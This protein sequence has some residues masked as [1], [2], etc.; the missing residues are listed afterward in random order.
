MNPLP[1][2][3][4][5]RERELREHNRYITTQQNGTI[6]IKGVAK[7]LGLYNN[8]A[9]YDLW[10]SNYNQE[11]IQQREHIAR[12]RIGR[13]IQ[14]RLYVEPPL[15]QFNV[16]T[17]KSI[18]Y[19]VARTDLIRPNTTTT[20]ISTFHYQNLKSIPEIRNNLIQI[21]NT[22]DRAYKISL[23]FE[24]MFEL[25]VYIEA[26][27]TTNARYEYQYKIFR[28]TSNKYF[29]S[30]V[31]INKIEDIMNIN[32]DKELLHGYI[33]GMRPSSSHKVI[34]I[35][36]MT[37][38]VLNLKKYKYLQ[39]FVYGSEAGNAIVRQR[40][41]ELRQIR[42]ILPHHIGSG[43]DLPNYITKNRNI[44]SMNNATNNM[45]FWNCLGYYY[46]G[47]KR[48]LKK[49]N[50][51]FTTFYGKKPD[52][53]YKGI[54]I[55]SELDVFESIEGNVGINIYN[56][57]NTSKY[58]LIRKSNKSQ[59]MDLLLYENHFSYIVNTPI[60]TETLYLPDYITDNGDIIS[61][62]NSTNNM[63]FWDCVGSFI[64]NKKEDFITVRNEYFEL[65]YGKKPYNRYEGFDVE[66][67]GNDFEILLDLEINEIIE[68]LERDYDINGKVIHN[69]KYDLWEESYPIYFKNYTNLRLRTVK[70]IKDYNKKNL[71]I[72]RLLQYKTDGKIHYS[73]I[74]DIENMMKI[75]FSCGTCGGTF[76]DNDSL[77]DHIKT[78]ENFQQKDTFIKFPQIYEPTR[79]SIVVLNEVFGTD[80]DI[81]YE[82]LIVYDF[83]S[84]VY[85]LNIQ[86][87]KTTKIT[88]EQIPI[89][90]SIC[91]NVEGYETPKCIINSDIKLL[92]KEMFSYMKEITDLAVEIM[93]KKLNSINTKIIEQINDINEIK[94]YQKLLENYI[95]R[96]PILGFNSG[97]YDMNLNINEFINGLRNING[98]EFSN[99]KTGNTFK[100]LSS[101]NMMFLDMTQYLP[102]TYNLS[103]Y[104]IA[105]NKSRLSKNTFPF[106]IKN[107]INISSNIDKLTLNYI[108]VK[109]W[110]KFIENK[111][112]YQWETVKDLLDYYN[113]FKNEEVFI[114]S[115]CD[116]KRYIQSYNESKGTFPYEY[117]NSFEMVDSDIDLLNQESFF[118]KLKNKGISTDEWEEFLFNKKKYGWK[119]L[120]DLLIFYNNQ[121]VKPFLNAIL[122]HKKFF[123]E[124]NLDMFKDGMSLPALAEKTMFSFALKEFN[125]IFLK[126]DIEPF[127]EE[128]NYCFEG[129]KTN[130]KPFMSQI[131]GVYELDTDTKKNIVLKLKS[132]KQ[133]DI[134]SGRYIKNE[135]IGEQEINDLFKKQNC[136]CKYCWKV[137][138]NKKNEIETDGV[139]KIDSTTWSLDRINNI[140]GH[141]TGNCVLSCL[142]CNKQRKDELYNV[143]YRKKALIRY[144]HK[145]PLIYLID[146]ENK[147]VFD[148]LKSNITGGASI[149]FHRHH[150]SG[151]TR[152][153]RP[154]YDPKTQQW[155]LGKNGNT[156]KNI[157]GYDAN[158]LY[159]WCIGRS[160]P[161]GILKWTEWIEGDNINLFIKD[162]N[163]FVEVDI[164]TPEHLYNLMGE[165]PLIFKNIEYDKNE[166]MGE[167]MKSLY[168]KDELKTKTLTRKLISSFKGDK[169]LIKSDRLKWLVEKG[170][171]VSKIYG[172]IRTEKGVIF[173]GFVKKV[174]DER[175]KGDIDPDYAIIAEMWK[176]IGNS[177]FGRTGMNKNKFTKTI[178]GGEDLYDKHIATTLF[179][180]ANVFDD[181]L[182]EITLKSRNVKQN[183]PIQI[184]NS[185]YDD[186]KLLMSRFYYDCMDK[187]ISRDDYQYIQMDTD[188]A[189]IAFTGKFDELVKPDM[190]DEY[191]K[192]KHNWFLRKDT[193]ENEAFDK[194]V[195][196]LFK[197]EFEGEEMVA[198]CSKSY[199]VKGFDE[200]A[201][202]GKDNF[203]LS[204]KGIQRNNN[205][206]KLTMDSHKAVL[207]LNKK[208]IVENRGMRIMNDKQIYEIEN[209]LE[210]NKK[211][212][213]YVVKKVGLSGKYDKR[214]ILNDG[215]S[216]VP[217][218]I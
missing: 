132:Y 144:S 142:T 123:Y 30:G 75:K 40:A 148:K 77:N 105:F 64:S 150:Q 13:F 35:T 31:N 70:K 29:I 12:T 211:I 145:K 121:D 159:L 152:I 157:T 42:S 27:D 22:M 9:V 86:I 63:S 23:M 120:R 187:Y 153:K 217:L 34:G 33:L 89:S 106:N 95:Q 61:M 19:E 91:S 65:F 204:C 203:K 83:E 58:T 14:Q 164:H 49:T 96:V 28:A 149:V 175:R 78:C 103:Q 51:L 66:K 146:E 74:T 100:M 130:I 140:L 161:C 114:P 56:M 97:R 166:V 134:V 162:F 47:N 11:R 199:H 101:G 190:K 196:G 110:G 216:S 116:V 67:D 163:G 191:E 174:S 185:I 160:M 45:C 172:F 127:K 183:I 85:P 193:K 18:A 8:K 24:F 192:D 32:L 113:E 181:D 131:N 210:K 21:H 99:I 200:K 119:T 214:R 151:K 59:S 122:E 72:I 41:N 182:Y 84:V 141:N 38:K 179:V 124:L 168:D 48:C 104:I 205:E 129:E 189:Y 16:P 173:D 209:D 107:D 52:S 212:Y 98:N 143:F 188:S 198:L 46:V 81:K 36:G 197:P 128:V 171:V 139:N 154:I 87:G 37:V 207:Y 68:N 136:K 17:R 73:L 195:A 117:M 94:K 15:I 53:S 10:E 138:D 43:I 184:A 133:Q 180:D 39:P 109:E 176:L 57:D 170:L 213:N 44:I 102:P 126:T 6:S 80:Y 206:D 108:G 111:E 5:L 135:F 25:R 186:S 115:I 92:F 118:S 54:D 20:N 88:N 7:I 79:N 60:M 169:V 71:M 2:N 215:I 1:L 158:A 218:D 62:K 155:N 178:Y 55:N 82:P 50:E 147:I 90:V 156:V 208:S 112:K 93:R 202:K 76:R 3:R 194:R 69:E 165:F 26:T 201:V 137:M 125:D 167:Y 4:R 177:A